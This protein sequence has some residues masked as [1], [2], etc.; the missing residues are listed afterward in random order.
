VY[1]VVLA[2]GDGTR[3]RPLTSERPKGLVEVAGRPILTHCFE[4][5]VAAGVDELVVVVGY[6]GD[7]IVSYY[8]E[9]FGDTPV[10]YTVQEE[11]LGSAHALATV[12]PRVDGTART[13]EADGAAGT[14]DDGPSAE[15][16]GAPTLLVLNGDNVCDADLSAVVSHHRDRRRTRLSSLTTSLGRKRPAQ[17]SS[18]STTTASPALSRSRT[19]RRR[20]RFHAASTRSR[21]GSS[22]PVGPSSHPQ[23]ASTSSQRRSTGCSQPAAGSNSSNS[24]AGVST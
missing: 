14:G 8:G 10:S 15:G 7:D 18:P 21:P 3:L 4:S 19:S 1:G 24:T 12:A 22:R 2:A 20:R 23:L 17:A 5:L 13:D 16:D 6:R 9:R 11:R